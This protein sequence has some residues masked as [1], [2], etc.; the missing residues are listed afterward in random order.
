MTRTVAL[1][2][3]FLAAATIAAQDL[4]I[5]QNGQHKLTT[6]NA[7]NAGSNQSNGTFPTCIN[8]SGVIAGEV[9]GLPVFQSFV[10][11][12]DGTITDFNVPGGSIYST[13]ATAI[14]AAGTIAGVYVEVHNNNAYIAYGFVR[15]TDGTLTRFSAPGA[16][17]GAYPYHQGT[18]PTSIN[19][20]GRIAGYYTDANG[21]SH[22]FT[23]TAGGIFTSFDP[24]G[25]AGTFVESINATGVAAGYYVDAASGTDHGFVRAAD[26]TIT[27]F[28]P[29][30]AGGDGRGTFAWKI[31]D[32]GIITGYFSNST[33]PAY[34]F[35]RDAGGAI[36]TFSAPGA[37][38]QGTFAVSING[39]GWVAG[40]YYG[41]KGDVRGFT[42][43][44]G[45]TI[46]TFV[47]PGAGTG[48]GYPTYPSG[49]SDTGAVT[50]Y[51]TDGELAGHGFVLF[52]VIRQI[53][54]EGGA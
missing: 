29:T 48:T 42:R 15:A 14:N 37:A 19:T 49:I 24:D 36:T 23:R 12:A 28:D 1:A 33:G 32:R 41:S 16:G 4:R 43:A 25:S 7:P 10:R 45:G 38:E 52:P 2:S 30:G 21:V 39:V 26:G 31:N 46:S 40:Y 3:C 9:V 5:I 8:T 53:K 13:S 17:S 47:V 50:G 34:G 44:A 22:G 35:V 6:F 20:A 11:S 51:Y 27:A 54:K 18:V